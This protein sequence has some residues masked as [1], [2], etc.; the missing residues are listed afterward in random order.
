MECLITYCVLQVATVNT[1]MRG[2]LVGQKSAEGADSIGIG[3]RIQA[4]KLAQES[5]NVNENV[6]GE[7]AGQK[8]A[9]NADS[10]GIA[11]SIGAS[12]FLHD[13]TNTGDVSAMRRSHSS[14]S[15]SSTQRRRRWRPRLAW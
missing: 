4:G 15:T 12:P 3:G 9:M 2:E 8:S 1:N 7:L 13:T 5:R 11:H 6:R 14:P 10:M